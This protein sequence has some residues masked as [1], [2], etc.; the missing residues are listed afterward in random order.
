VAGYVVSVDG[1]FFD[2]LPGTATSVF[3]GGL[4]SETAFTFD[5]FAF[6]P[7]GNNSGDAEITVSTDAEIDTGEPGLV[8][9]YPFDGNANDATPF[10]NHGAIGGNP[11]FEDVTHPNGTGG[12]AI[13]FDGDQDS[14]LAANAVQLISDFAS[15]SFWIRVDAITTDPEAYV[16]TFGNWDQR[17]KI[18]L[19]THLKIVWTTNST[20][21]VSEN[22]IHDMDSGD[23]NELLVGIWWFLT[24]VHDGVNDIIYLNGDKVA[25]FPAAGTLNT[26]GRPL[27]MGSNAT[28]GGQY[29]TGALDELK[30]YN[31]ALTP[32]EVATLFANGG[33]TA[34]NETI[35]GEVVRVVQSVYPNPV[36]DQLIIKHTL[37]NH[38]PLLLRVLD[39]QGREMDAIQ[40]N[41]NELPPDQF[42]I[43]V[44]QYSPGTYFLN[45]ISGGKNLGSVKFSKQ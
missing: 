41:K 1:V 8:A 13:V 5:V 20:N 18:S 39:V 10:L 43:N 9:W 31:L 38:Q 45:F 15:V 34:V 25:E 33:I 14:V 36:S 35:K 22:F 21:D 6:D 19:P 44:S 40:Y 30:I 16:I 27:G 4:D 42:S 3:I 2:S 28:T 17:W 11:V 24:M 7:A 12:Q 37:N 26:T 23:G 32:E 29:F